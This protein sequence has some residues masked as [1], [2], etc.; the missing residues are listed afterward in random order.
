MKSIKINTDYITLGQLLKIVDLIS[1]GGEVKFFLSE[2]KVYVNNELEQRRGRKLYKG[3]I[4]KVCE[5]E[6]KID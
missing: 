3:Y 1:S 4:I 5:N 2:N 6:Y